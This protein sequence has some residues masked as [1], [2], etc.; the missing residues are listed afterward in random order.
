MTAAPGLK[1]VTKEKPDDD[2]FVNLV[3]KATLVRPFSMMTLVNRR[4]ALRHKRASVI[5][6]FKQLP[7]IDKHFLWPANHLSKEP[8]REGLMCEQLMLIENQS[9]IRVGFPPVK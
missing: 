1:G 8:G 4:Q 7:S 5:V 3:R 2:N 9:E 6:S